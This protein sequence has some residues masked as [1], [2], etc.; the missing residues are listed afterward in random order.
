[1][2]RNPQVRTARVGLITFSAGDGGNDRMLVH[3]A[4]G[5]SEHGCVVDFLT[6][7]TEA[8]YLGSLPS[9]VKRL[10]IEGNSETERLRRLGRYVAEYRPDVLLSG[11]RSD[12]EAL[13]A[14][15]SAQT[16]TRVFFRV[17]TTF[18]A[19]NENRSMLKTWWRMRRLRRLFPKAHGVIA[20]SHGVA[21]DVERL[22]GV[23]PE[24]IHVVPNPVVTPEMLEAPPPVPPHPFFAAPRDV[25]VVMGMGGLRKAKDFPT[26]LRAFTLM[27]QEKPARLII[28]GKGH[29]KERL[30][31]L[32]RSLGIER[33][34]DFPGFVENPYGYLAHADLF[35]LSSLWEGSPNVLTEA[36]A[37]GTAVVATDCPSGP[38]EILQDGRYGRLVPCGDP[39]AMARA[40]VEALEAPP[41]PAFLKQAVARYTLAASSR[42]HLKAFGLLGAASDES[43]SRHGA[44]KADGEP[45]P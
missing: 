2:T 5:L 8:P 33:W 18:S 42:E 29:L 4:R 39:S 15:R 16:E 32:A 19:R 23:P 43:P 22:L 7:T 11:K 24:R 30:V 34:T 28:L 14:V 17:G 10:V 40:M 41:E 6:R 44:E 31:A 20:V 45:A 35:V 13:A 27:I 9:S 12:A 36:L 38:R 21:R 37:M 25:P 3:L 26:L 1:M